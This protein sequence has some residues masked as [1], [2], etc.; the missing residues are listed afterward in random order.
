MG[1][2]QSKTA[3]KSRKRDPKK[4][5][6]RGGSGA[7]K[8]TKRIA[9]RTKIVATL[10]PSSRSLAQIRELI[11]AGVD[12]FRINFSHGVPSEHGT[13]IRN[14]RRGA[15]LESRPVAILADLQGPKIR[16]GA[17]ENGGPVLLKR[18]EPLVIVADPTLIGVEGRVGCTYEGLPNDVVKGDRILLDDGGLEVKVVRVTDDEV[19]TKV[20]YGGLLRPGKGINLPG[21][22]VSAPS[23]GQKD[24]FD[25]DF[26]LTHEVDYIA[27]SFV[28]S[29]ADVRGLR[30]RIAAFGADVEIIAKIER[31]EAIENLEAIVDESDGVMVARGDM[32]VELGPEA[33]PVIQKRIIRSCIER[34]KPVITATQMLESM[35]DHPRPTRAEASDVANAI[36]DGS[37]ALML[38]AET[39]AG[40]YPE[41]VVR[42]MDRIARRTESELYSGEGRIQRLSDFRR[43]RRPGEDLPISVAAVSAAAL[44]SYASGAKLVVCFTETGRTAKLLARER[45]P[46]RLMAFTPRSRTYHRLSLH[47]GINP[48]LT[49]RART[50][51]QMYRFAEEQLLAAGHAKIGDRIV[52]LAGTLQVAGATNSLTIREIRATTD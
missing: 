15:R 44:A 18:G 40:Q 6:K 43:K 31:P 30:R 47:W 24:L 34:A 33:V 28:R 46:A 12:V 14:V 52:Y 25:L 9:T 27:L 49:K 8:G 10:G 19:H 45:L 1:A 11:R 29:V 2:K 32:G 41:L 42:T 17:L 5:A 38:S 22:E 7:R 20:R 13:A 26:A 35:I 4:A 16:I 23:L 50:P 21:T 37:S 51:E 3:K 48:M 39:A 36:Y